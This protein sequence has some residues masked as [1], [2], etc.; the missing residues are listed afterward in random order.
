MFSLQTIAIIAIGFVALLTLTLHLILDFRLRKLFK[1][2]KT[3]NIDEV[4]IAYR[5]AIEDIYEISDEFK[6]SLENHESRI[7]QKVN[8][9]KTL[10]FNALNDIAGSQS[11]TTKMIDEEGNG[12]IISTLH[13]RE[14]T[15]IFAKPVNIWSTEQELS[16][17]EQELLDGKN[18]KQT[19]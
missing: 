4:L 16:K 10:R 14:K 7:R 17:E 18:K 8:T 1:T 3:E 15:S 5:K 6:K 13:A 11:F 9:P 2:G 12:V 19:K